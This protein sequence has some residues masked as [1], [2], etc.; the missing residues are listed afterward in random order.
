MNSASQAHAP[1]RAKNFPTV[2]PRHYS[3]CY[4]H[5]VCPQVVFLPSLQE[6]G[7]V[8]WVHF[9]PVPSTFKTPGFKRHWMQELRKFSPFHFLSQWLG[10]CPPCAFP[11]VFLSLSPFSTTMAP[12]PPHCV[13]TALYFRP[14]I[15]KDAPC[16][17]WQCLVPALNV[18]SLN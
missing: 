14:A 17:L 4:F 9:Q 12:S 13:L 15:F 10:K 3:D 11:S 1:K 2:C 5:A 16:L 6:Q 8:L 18:V 7:S